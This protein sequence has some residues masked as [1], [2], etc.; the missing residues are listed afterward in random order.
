MEGGFYN[1]QH[2]HLKFKFINSTFKLPEMTCIIMVVFK[3]LQKKS[4][5][6]KVPQSSPLE[7]KPL[8][9]NRPKTFTNSDID[10]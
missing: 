10:A 8:F 6:G 1:L 5:G 9:R 4:G 3:I 2:L 7:L